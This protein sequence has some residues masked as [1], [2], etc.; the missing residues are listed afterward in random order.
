MYVC[1]GGKQ[2]SQC[3]LQGNHN[4]GCRSQKHIST[5]EDWRK[6]SAVSAAWC[7]VQRRLEHAVTTTDLGTSPTTTNVRSRAF[8]G[9]T[10]WVHAPRSD[11]IIIARCRWVPRRTLSPTNAL[12]F[13]TFQYW[14]AQKQNCAVVA[15]GLFLSTRRL[16]SG[17]G[18]VGLEKYALQNVGWL[19]FNGTFST[20]VY[21]VS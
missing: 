8:A 14:R 18:N 5:A 16:T 20:A 11:V 12:L 19:V 6:S 15:H 9:S 17:D 2:K 3:L 10:S 4:A 21:I 7:Y 1:D 13:C